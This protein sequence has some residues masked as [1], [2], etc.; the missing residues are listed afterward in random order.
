MKKI[1]SFVMIAMLAIG[2]AGCAKKTEKDPEVPAAPNEEEQ[3]Q[4]PYDTELSADVI[5]VGAGAA[6][7]S[8][9][10]RAA[11]Y[12]AEKVIIVDKMPMTGGSLNTTSGTI[13][14]A[15]TIIQELDGLTE[16]SLESYKEDII[17]EGSKLNG[18]P[19]EEL[20]DLYVSGTQKMVNWMWEQGLSDNEFTTDKEGHK[21]V[22]A[23]EHT[24]YSYPRSYKM[25]PHTDQYKS[26]VHELLDEMVKKNPNIELLLNTEVTALLPNEKGQVLSALASSEGKTIKLTGTK[27]IIM[28]TG[29]Y[30][31]NPKLMAEFNEY[32][33]VI[34]TGGLPSADGQGLRLMQTVGGALDVD[35]MG[36][37]PTYPMGLESLQ[38]PGTGRIATTKTQFAGGILVNTEGKR[39]INETDQDNVAR[40]VALEKQP[41]GVQYEIYTDKIAADIIAAGQGGMLQYLFMTDAFKPYVVS[42]SSLEELAEKLDLPKDEFLQTVSKY[43]QSVDEKSTD[44]FGRDFTEPK[45]PFNVAINKIE[46]ETFYAVRIRPLAIITLGGIKTNN[47]MQVLDENG[48]EI[49]GLYAAGETVGGIWGRYISSGT[50]VMGPVVFGDIAAEQIMS[51]TLTEGYTIKE[52]SNILPE[53]IF[54]KEAAEITPSDFTMA[55]AKD[56]TYEAEVDGQEGKM[57][58]QITIDTEKIT[59]VEI[60]SHHETATIAAPALDTLPDLIVKENSID[61]DTVSGAT[62]T[63]KRLLEAVKIAVDNAKK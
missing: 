59:A 48:T 43:N 57:T 58:V 16:D 7:L 55:G 39:F 6:G 22:F 28:A 33:S 60:L 23:P 14:G 15:E 4:T 1:L 62:L 26:A 51:A 10:I 31:G 42:A 2:A 52:A 29:G 18:K 13:S 61:V 25:K 11:E 63:S 47:N 30:S 45:A 20:I 41:G 34:I 50:G 37:I 49:P 35:S 38:V 8:A 36:W 21:S 9:A 12:G 44:E 5:I 32:G 3:E 27:G 40:E 19:N 17:A 53:D 54:K 56:G 24:L 46:G